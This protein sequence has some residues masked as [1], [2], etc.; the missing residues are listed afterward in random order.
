MDMCGL[1]EYEA[2]LFE[3]P[4]ALA[5]VKQGLDDAAKGKISRV[6]LD[7]L[8]FGMDIRGLL[9]SKHELKCILFCVPICWAVEHFIW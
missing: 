5:L 9:P 4:E 7:N 6:E 3:N 2:W 1:K 8:R